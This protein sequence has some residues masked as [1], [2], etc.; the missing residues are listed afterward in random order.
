MPCPADGC[1]G[2]IPEG[3][4]ACAKCGAARPGRKRRVLRALVWLLILLVLVSVAASAVAIW[5]AH[6]DQ[7]LNGLPPAVQTPLR[8]WRDAARVFIDG[9]G[10]LPEG[11]APSGDADR[12]SD[13]TQPTQPP[14]DTDAGNEPPAPA[15]PT[16]APAEPAPV[17]PAPVEP[18]EPA[19]VEPAP[20][21]P[22]EPAEPVG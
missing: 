2:E 22:A 14:A 4:D 19:P 7:V 5:T 1:D 16:P 21:E 18:A 9:K 20:V 10:W 15:E 8:S 6:L 17:E 13:G 3:A 12:P 11:L